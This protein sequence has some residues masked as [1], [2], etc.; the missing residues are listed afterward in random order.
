MPHLILT[1][2]D[3]QILKRFHTDDIASV[4]AVE[5]KP[6]KGFRTIHKCN[7]IL[8]T[9]ETVRVRESHEEIT[10]TL[11]GMVVST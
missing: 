8:A 4:I 1:L 10:T 11:K 3:G 6:E 5:W 7:I 9:G 2:T